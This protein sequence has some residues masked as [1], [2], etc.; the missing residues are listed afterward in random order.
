MKKQKSESI[1]KLI[2]TKKIFEFFQSRLI[3]CEFDNS[4]SKIS[5]DV[6]YWFEIFF[7]RFYWNHFARLR[8]YYFDWF[9][10]NRSKSNFFIVI[11]FEFDSIK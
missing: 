2:S 7:D 3:D 11:K 10:L 4:L 8:R 9:D 6:F 5:F 1:T